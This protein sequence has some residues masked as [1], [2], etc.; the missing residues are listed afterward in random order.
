MSEDVDLVVKSLENFSRTLKT[1]VEERY[2][3]KIVM[4]GVIWAWIVR[5]PGFLLTRY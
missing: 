1:D 5:H 4:G 3:V 2:G